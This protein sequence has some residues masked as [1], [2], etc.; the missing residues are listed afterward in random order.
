MARPHIHRML[1]PALVVIAAF[2]QYSNTIRN[3]FAWDDSLVIIE[4]DYTKQGISGL[5]DIFTK[6][7][8]VPYKNVYRPIPQA[9]FALEYQFF[10]GSPHWMHLSSIL[11]YSLCCLTIFYFLRYVLPNASPVFCFMVTLL[12]VVHPLHVEVVANVKSRDEVMALVFSLWGLLLLMK[13]LERGSISLIL[14]AV[15]CFAAAFLSK[16]NSIAL[17]PMA[18][19]GI[20]FRAE[21]LRPKPE[22]YLALA[23]ILLFL[24]IYFEQ[25]LLIGAGAICLAYSVWK[26]SYGRLTVS[27]T[28]AAAALAFWLGTRIDDPA[29]TES[30]RLDSSVLNNIFLWTTESEKVLPTAI[31]NIGRYVKL[32]LYP[33]PLLHLYGY[34]QIPLR[35]WS[36]PA[37]LSAISLLALAGLYLWFNWKDKRPGVFGL[38]FFGLSYSVYSNIVVLAP[39]TMADRYLFIPS[40]GLCLLLVEGLFR[41]G[42]IPLDRPS[43]AGVGPKIVVAAFCIVIG[44]FS[45]RSWIGNTDW[46]DDETL[47]SNRIKYMQTNAAAHANMGMVY[48]NKSAQANRPEEHQASRQ[49]AMD[50]FKRALEI[51]PDFH[52]VWVSVGQVFAENGDFEKAE[53]AFLKAQRLEP[54]SPD[55]YYSMG[56]LYSLVG[57]P[58]FA[59]I[60]LERSLLLDPNTEETYV[61]LGES[62]LKNND[63]DNL[64]SMAE[65]ARRWFPER[66]EFDAFLAVFFLKKGDHE[67]AAQNARSALQKDPHS[68][69]AINVLLSIP[70]ER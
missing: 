69:L 1:F 70:R 6:R 32:F 28:L 65:T 40:L 2:L 56:A 68:E 14:L 55:G 18:A 36:H 58:E 10:D 53:L 59:I 46:Y 24:G 11:W 23:L 25:F 49:A 33:H 60:Y 15:P 13:G 64:A 42:Q 30:V 20:W 66:G 17:L 45:L 4:N 47:I 9:A 43:L 62:Y 50:S 8:S 37:T 3:Q 54:F 7:V 52:W 48:L 38:I 63:I 61:L 12:F 31:V 26:K 19:A 51:Y 5:K 27:L 67:K 35:G 57:E 29:A 44:G 39:D 22:F 41:I 34:D 16:E 21:A